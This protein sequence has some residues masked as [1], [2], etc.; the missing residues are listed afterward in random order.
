MRKS[1]AIAS[2][3]L[4]DNV[5]GNSLSTYLQQLR[6]KN[7]LLYI[8]YGVRAEV[9]EA[10]DNEVQTIEYHRLLKEGIQQGFIVNSRHKY[11]LE[12][13]YKN[14][15][16][17][18]SGF[19]EKLTEA[20][21]QLI[22]LSLQIGIEIDTMDLKIIKTLSEIKTAPHLHKYIMRLMSHSSSA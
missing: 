1:I 13:E 17:N 20:D 10:L 6:K 4:I 21:R 7:E 9:E 19:K 8:P 11:T 3:K 2:D 18:L 12:H 22:A 5:R 14:L 15:Y 16:R